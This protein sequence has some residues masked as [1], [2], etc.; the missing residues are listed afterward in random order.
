[1]L[2]IKQ[3]FLVILLFW[4]VSNSHSAPYR[5]LGGSIAQSDGT[6][7]NLFGVGDFDES[8]LLSSQFISEV[9]PVLATSASKFNRTVFEFRNWQHISGYP[10]PTPSVD[11][12]NLHA[13]FT[14]MVLLL[15]SNINGIEKDIFGYPIGSTADL[16]DNGNGSYTARWI[17]PNIDFD[18]WGVDSGGQEI[19]MT[20]TPIP[21]PG[22]LLL[23]FSG[24]FSSM[25]FGA[26]KH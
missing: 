22:A 21:L 12:Q 9:N 2:I 10:M 23:F 11:F 6:T 5:V 19:S 14:S 13:D 20:F 1:M 25:L 7:F 15:T 16:T 18:T 8:M 4:V 3:I 24:F 17:T 26:W